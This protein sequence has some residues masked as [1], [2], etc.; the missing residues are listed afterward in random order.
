MGI[1]PMSPAA[2][3]AVIGSPIAHSRSPQM[4]NPA[5]AACGLDAQYV[6]I[7]VPPGV[8]ARAFN[9]FRRQ[10]F[11]GVNITIPHKREALEAVEFLDPLARQL[12]TVNTLAIRA[13]RFWGFNTDGPGFLRSLREAMSADPKGMSI[14]VLGAGGGAGRAVAIQCALAKCAELTLINRGQDRLR[15]LAAE[16]AQIAPACRLRCLT[17]EA[18]NLR[19][20]A[21][22]ADLLI[23]ATSLGMRDEDPVLYNAADLGTKPL[24]YDMVYRKTGPTAL[25]SAAIEAGC[26]HADG[27]SLLLHQGAL[28]FE[29]WFERDAPLEVMRQ[30]LQAL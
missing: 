20:A 25:I 30:A 24:V 4:H 11:W 27:M 22:G 1:E 29:H 3:L 8:V 23:N 7:E 10:G 13:G 9:E 21:E 2:R 18:A 6:R 28:S 17:H 12:G 5:L 14:A 26:P 15:E 19:R 16:L